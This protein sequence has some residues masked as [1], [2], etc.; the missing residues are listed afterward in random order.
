MPRLR[1]TAALLLLYC[2]LRVVDTLLYER[3]AQVL[4]LLRLC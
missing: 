3:D 4:L 1:F 2:V